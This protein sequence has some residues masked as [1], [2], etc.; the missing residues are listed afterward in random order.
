[1]REEEEEQTSAYGLLQIVFALLLL[2][3]LLLFACH[4]FYCSFIPFLPSSCV[5]GS[6]TCSYVGLLHLYNTE[7]TITLFIILAFHAF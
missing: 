3:L 7:Q 5:V 2:L 1:M 4:F 6:F